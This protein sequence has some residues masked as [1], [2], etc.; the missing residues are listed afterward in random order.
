MR[1]GTVKAEGR[2]DQFIDGVKA[3]MALD[4]VKLARKTL[5]KAIAGRERDQSSI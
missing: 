2:V 1:V 5:F 4:K 3:K